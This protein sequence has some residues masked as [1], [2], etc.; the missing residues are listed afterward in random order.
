[1]G[2]FVGIELMGYNVNN[3]LK[4]IV[5]QLF[6]RTFFIPNLCF[7]PEVIELFVNTILF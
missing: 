2:S 7:V 1:M 5:I 4:V 3:Y 6:L